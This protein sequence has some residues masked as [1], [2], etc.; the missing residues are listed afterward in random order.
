MDGLIGLII[1]AVISFIY[2]KVM[3]K[4]NEQ[5]GNGADLSQW[6]E[7][8]EPEEEAKIAQKEPL[9]KRPSEPLVQNTKKEQNI[10][11]PPKMDK[12]F[13]SLESPSPPPVEKYRTV[14]AEKTQNSNNQEFT[15]TKTKKRHSLNYKNRKTLRKAFILNTV[16]SKAKAYEP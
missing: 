5:H 3:E 12:P 2:N 4:Q 8:A 6:L 16:L 15:K 7:E 14:H 13:S 11:N 1:F 10:F 9:Q